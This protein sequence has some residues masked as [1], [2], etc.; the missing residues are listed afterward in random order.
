MARWSRIL[1]QE[2]YVSDRL[3]AG[4][5]NAMNTKAKRIYDCGHVQNIQVCVYSSF[6]W[7]RADCVP[8]M[9]K[10]LYIR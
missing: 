4:D 10:I 2:L 5:F 6:L 1:Y 8:E 9:K 7:I 3:P